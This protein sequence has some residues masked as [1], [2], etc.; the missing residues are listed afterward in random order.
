MPAQNA[1][2]TIGLAIQSCLSQT[3]HD[4]EMVLV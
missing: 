2:A 1:E 4:F 3:L